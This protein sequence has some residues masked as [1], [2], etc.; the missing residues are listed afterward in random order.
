MHQ[1]LLPAAVIQ[2]RAQE[3]AGRAISLVK[4]IMQ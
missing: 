1:S 3:D 2:E 4:T